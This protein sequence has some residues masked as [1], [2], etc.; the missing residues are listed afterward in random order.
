MPVEEI[1]Y[2]SPGTLRALFARHGGAIRKRL[3]Q[4]FLMD[5]GSIRRIAAVVLELGA[6]SKTWA[7]IGPGAGALTAELLKERNITA[8]EIDPVAIKILEERFALELEAGRLQIM[9]GDAR[10]I[11]PQ[12]Q[13]GGIGCGNLPYYISTELLL[14]GL[15]AFQTCV[16][17][18]QLDFARR[19]LGE[20]SSLGIYVGNM[21]WRREHF[22]LSSAVFY[23]RPSVD[24]AL[25][26]LVKREAPLS[27]PNVLESILRASFLARRKKIGNS[28]KISGA[29]TSQWFLKAADLGMDLNARAEEIPAERYYELAAAIEP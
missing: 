12:W 11:L 6:G 20:D 17:L 29:A 24:S 28:W 16:F 5:P 14:L 25:V 4:N 22:R 15:S 13:A 10:E 1:S 18:F 2:T 21:A 27:P 3:G 23:P 9:A 7:E 19:L 26:S 8:L